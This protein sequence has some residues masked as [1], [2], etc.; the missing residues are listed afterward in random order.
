VDAYFKR[1]EIREKMTAQI[2]NTINDVRKTHGV[3][4]I[5][6]VTRRAAWLIALGVY[7]AARPQI[8]NCTSGND[9]VFV[10]SASPKNT[11]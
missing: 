3:G 1:T 6:K 8:C 4:A 11:L 5:I 9:L 10:H 2:G 7:Q